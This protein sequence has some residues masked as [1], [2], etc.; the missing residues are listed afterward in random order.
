MEILMYH[1][2]AW[3]LRILG[4]TFVYIYYIHSLKARFKNRTYIIACFFAVFPV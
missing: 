2:S 1:N 3:Y 4:W